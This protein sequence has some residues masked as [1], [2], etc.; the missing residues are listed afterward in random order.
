M[1][2]RRTFPLTNV[3]PHQ[4]L[5]SR[6]DKAPRDKIIAAVCMCRKNLTKKISKKCFI[7][8]VETV[9]GRRR[10]TVRLVRTRATRVARLRLSETTGDIERDNDKVLLSKDRAIPNKT[11]FGNKEQRINY[12]C[13]HID[14]VA[15]SLFS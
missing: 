3:D 1:T 12:D 9:L 5:P 10:H 8:N 6:Y 13:H 14:I 11:R 4:S 15:V 2:A 7:R